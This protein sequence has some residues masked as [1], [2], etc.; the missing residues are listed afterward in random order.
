MQSL[1]SN[2]SHRCIVEQS[3]SWNLFIALN[4]DRRTG[5]RLRGFK[6]IHCLGIASH[7]GGHRLGVL[8]QT[9]SASSQCGVPLVGWDG[10][11]QGSICER[12][13]GEVLEG[14]RSG[15]A[16]NDPVGPKRFNGG[17]DWGERGTRGDSRYIRRTRSSS[18]RSSRQASL[19]TLVSMTGGNALIKTLAWRLSWARRDRWRL[20]DSSWGSW[21]DAAE[22]GGGKSPAKVSEA[23]SVT[24][25]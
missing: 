15:R 17:G 7:K 16:K 5:K 18:A 23:C 19:V 8:A 9:R 22:M 2:H 12:G 24:H 3:Q 25:K 10:L 4:W 21:F 11:N 1:L 14:K 13:I 20:Y 6:T